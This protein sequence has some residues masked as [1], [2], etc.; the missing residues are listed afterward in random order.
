[1]PLSEEKDIVDRAKDHFGH[2]VEQDVARLLLSYR[3]IRDFTRH[4]IMRLIDRRT[5]DKSFVIEQPGELFCVST[6]SA[7]SE[8]EILCDLIDRCR[9]KMADD[10]MIVNIIWEM[11]TVQDSHVNQVLLTAAHTVQPPL[12]LQD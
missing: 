3:V 9:T 6:S 11:S 7:R 5:R 1:M 4:L 8:V 10:K 2:G 12:K